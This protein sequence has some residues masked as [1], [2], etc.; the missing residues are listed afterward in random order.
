MPRRWPASFPNLRIA[1]ERMGGIAERIR[2]M[3]A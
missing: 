2:G 1:D 3:R